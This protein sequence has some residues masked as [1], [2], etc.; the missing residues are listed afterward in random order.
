MDP[1]EPLPLTY[2]G[3]NKISHEAFEVNLTR[4]QGSQGLAE[5]E[6]WR[7]RFR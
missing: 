4:V 6:L 1:L 5:T 7:K 2:P 3:Q